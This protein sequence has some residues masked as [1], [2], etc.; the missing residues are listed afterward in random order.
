[1]TS[2]EILGLLNLP[3]GVNLDG[4]NVDVLVAT[5][6]DPANGGY[7]NIGFVYTNSPYDVK[8]LPVGYYHLFATIHV[9]ST[10]GTEPVPGDYVG[11]LVVNVTNFALYDMKD[12]QMHE[13]LPPASQMQLTVDWPVSSGGTNIMGTNWSGEIG[14]QITNAIPFVTVD[15]FFTNIGLGDLGEV[16]SNTSDLDYSYFEISVTNLQQ[17]SALGGSSYVDVR[18]TDTNG[19]VAHNGFYLIVDVEGPEIYS[20]LSNQT[21]VVGTNLKFE[22]DGAFDALTND[23]GTGVYYDDVLQTN[24]QG[25]SK[26]P[27]ISITNAGSNTIELRCYDELSNETVSNYVIYAT[28]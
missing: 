16:I 9:V 26:Y 3:N 5:N 22:F 4:S 27:I 11:D 13:M 21:V 12:I 18:A 23:T 2:A 6:D 19:Q 7:T 1:M 14:V 20:T 15:Y 28:N 17:L 8:D 25:N 24:V 10:V